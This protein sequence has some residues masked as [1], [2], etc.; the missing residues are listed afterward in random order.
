MGLIQQIATENPTWSAERIRGELLKLGIRVAK[1]TIRTHLRRVRRSPSAS[2]NWN[3]FLK[4]NAKDI[5]ACDF[6]LVIDLFFR[7]AYV[8]FIIDFSS[9]RVVHFARDPTS[10]R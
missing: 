1:D 6:L 9:R 7:T 5:W 8:F 3:T 10:K 4:N 2:H